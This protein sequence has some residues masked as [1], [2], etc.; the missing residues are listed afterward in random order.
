MELAEVKTTTLLKSDDLDKLSH[1]RRKHEVP[2]EAD[3]DVYE[4]LKSPWTLDQVERILINFCFKT[5]GDEEKLF[6]DPDIVLE[7]DVNIDY[8]IY[9]VGNDVY[10][11]QSIYEAYPF[12][13]L[14]IQPE[15]YCSKI[16]L[17][18]EQIM[19]DGDNRVSV[20]IVKRPNITDKSIPTKIFVANHKWPNIEIMKGA[21]EIM[22]DKNEAATLML[23]N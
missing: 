19:E 23:T 12:A 2:T 18:E 6:L 8:K 14:N 5:V 4:K 13:K 21:T 11:R 17:E 1:I 20:K 16:F 3:P 10:T 15:M 9:I 22:M 7:I